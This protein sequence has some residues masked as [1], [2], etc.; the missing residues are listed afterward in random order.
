MAKQIQFAED[1][2]QSLLNGVT[3]IAK[4]VKEHARSGRDVM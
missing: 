3:K 4:A 1:A 2:R